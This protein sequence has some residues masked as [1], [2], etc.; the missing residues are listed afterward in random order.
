MEKEDQEKMGIWKK[1]G[2]SDAYDGEQT[3]TNNP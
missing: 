2:G 1:D 3:T